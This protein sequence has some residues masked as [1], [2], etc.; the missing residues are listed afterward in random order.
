MQ[1][2]RQIVPRPSGRPP[3]W[4]ALVDADSGTENS[5]EDNCAENDDPYDE[6]NHDHDDC[7]FYDDEFTSDWS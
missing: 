2:M 4:I 3:P 1:S 7:D 6:Y 5:V